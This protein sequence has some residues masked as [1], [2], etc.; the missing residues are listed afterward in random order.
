[1]EAGGKVQ[2]LGFLRRLVHLKRVK[3]TPKSYMVYQDNVALEFLWLEKA[4]YLLVLYHKLSWLDIAKKN[5]ISLTLPKIHSQ[6][7]ILPKW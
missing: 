4:I 2:N 5:T 6:R 3:L 7:G 1:M